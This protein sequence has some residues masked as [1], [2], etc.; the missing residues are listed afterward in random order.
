MPGRDSPGVF[1][2][3]GAVLYLLQTES[4]EQRN[5]VKEEYVKTKPGFLSVVGD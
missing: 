2:V 1:G 5:D 3:V 4:G